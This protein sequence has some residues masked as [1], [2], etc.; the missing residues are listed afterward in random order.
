MKIKTTRFYSIKSLNYFFFNWLEKKT[1]FY[2]IDFVESRVE[3][4]MK[5]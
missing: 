1:Y 5:K 4:R 3:Y 2:F